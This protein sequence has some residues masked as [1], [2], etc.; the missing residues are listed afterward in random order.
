MK[1]NNFFRLAYINKYKDFVQDSF[2]VSFK[3]K[4]S[5]SNN[6]KSISKNS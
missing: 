1:K 5:S 2:F 3:D 6:E 4:L